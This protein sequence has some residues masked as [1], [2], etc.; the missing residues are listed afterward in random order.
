MATDLPRG[1]SA[2]LHGCAGGSRNGN[3]I[4]LFSGA[5]PGP[6]LVFCE[7]MTS[8]RSPCFSASIDI[9]PKRGGRAEPSTL[10][11]PLILQVHRTN[12]NSGLTGRICICRG[13][14]VELRKRPSN[15]R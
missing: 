3:S 5:L 15:N 6:P 1:W 10:R 4:P 14:M 2:S 13:E 12:A 7:A 9:S 11:S 8:Q